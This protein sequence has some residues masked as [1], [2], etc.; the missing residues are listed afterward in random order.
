MASYI[1]QAAPSPAEFEHI[2]IHLGCIEQWP[3]GH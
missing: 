1:A 2:L 3:R